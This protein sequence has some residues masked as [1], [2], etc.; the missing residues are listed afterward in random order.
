[1]IVT[2]NRGAE[3]IFGH[4]ADD[5]IGK[6]AAAVL[7]PPGG[8][9]EREETRTKLAQ[10][11]ATH[12]QVPIVRADG[13]RIMVSVTSSP[14]REA[15]GRWVGIS[16]I[17]RDVTAE[18]H[19]VEQ[20]RVSEA[21]RRASLDAL[22]Q[23]VAMSDLEGRV[24]MLNQGG[25]RMLGF[26]AEQ[27]TEL[28]AGGRWESY[29]EDGTILPPEQRPIRHTM[30]TGEPVRDAIVGWKTKK[31]SFVV[32]RVATQPMTDV[33]GNLAGVVTAFADITVER[34]QERERARLESARLE[35]V[36]QLRRSNT[37]LARSNSD[38]EEFTSVAAHD[39]KSPLSTIA[40]FAQMLDAGLGGP[41]EQQ[42]QEYAS[43]VLRGV[44]RM[45]ALIDDLLM[46]ARLGSVVSTVPTDLN[47]LVADVLDALRS[48]I[49][50]PAAMIEVGDLPS[51]DVDPT[52]AR[53]LV[54]NLLSNALKFQ[55]EGNTP[56]VAIKAAATDAG[57]EF[58]VTDNGIG[59]DP[60]F[61]DRIFRMFQRLHGQNA[62]GGTGIGLSICRRVVE[63]HGGRIWVDDGPDG[64]TR[65]TF[66]LS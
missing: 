60:R 16:S 66:T 44:Q 17:C 11:Q 52:Q 51:I 50:T 27:L 62:Y 36:A 7:A 2:W 53:Q 41:L 61:R 4:S 40:G 56:Q 9:S 19:A 12:R 1:M 30:D 45:Q 33:D 58:S 63:N 37:E 26:T 14:I 34:R 64:G 54:Q 3:Q 22:E 47:R 35:A 49:D 42:G 55:P 43:H 65:F 10:G 5:V 13:R 48:E 46:Y 8:E 39:L 31:D 29:R 15:D 25:E 23:G 24:L 32:L 59:I 38:L 57:W 6:E 28:V 18:H 21:T 20:L